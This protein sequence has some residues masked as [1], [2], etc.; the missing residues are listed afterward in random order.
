MDV[1]GPATQ[2]AIESWLGPVNASRAFARLRGG[3]GPRGRLIHVDPRRSQTALKADRWV[4]IVPGTDGLLALG[5]ANALIRE[6]LYDEDFV[7]Q[8]TTGFEAWTDARGQRHDGFR[9]LVIANN[10]LQ[11]TNRGTQGIGRIGDL[12]KNSFEEIFAGPVARQFRASLARGK[13]PIPTCVRCVELRR[14]S[15]RKAKPPE[16][17]LPHRGMLLEN[18]VRCNVDCTGCAREN[19]AGLRVNRQLQMPMAEMAKMADLVQRLG[20]RQLFYLNLG[21][22]FLSPTIG[23]E[24]PTEAAPAAVGGQVKEAAVWDVLKTCYDPEIPVNVV[25]LGLVYE[26][27]VEPHP[28]GEGFQVDVKMTLTAPGCGMGPVLQM[29][30]VAKLNSIKGVKRANVEIVFDPPWDREMMSDAAKLQLGM[31]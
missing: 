14:L 3:D 12:H 27:K 17:R 20:L 9:D 31:M 28:S 13:M 8:H 19:A 2:R 15:G 25:E 16:V 30:S 23:Q 21:E 11:A 6:G 22:P 29:D 18:T 4:P 24:L 5:I 7:R 26:V 1:F 10:R